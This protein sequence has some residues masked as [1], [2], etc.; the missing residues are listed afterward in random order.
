MSILISYVIVINTP[1]MN[2]TLEE[3]ERGCK[4]KL[5]V[6]GRWKWLNGLQ[7]VSVYEF[8]AEAYDLSSLIEH[9]DVL[10]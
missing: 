6:V 1:K 4:I 7:L 5:D 9:L 8:C 10:E 2:Q 3:Q